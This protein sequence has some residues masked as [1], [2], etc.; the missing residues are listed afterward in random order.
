MSSSRF[1][2][3]SSLTFA[4]VFPRIV[5]RFLAGQR[6]PRST[7]VSQILDLALLAPAIVEDLLL[8]LPRGRMWPVTEEGLRGIARVVGLWNKQGELWSTRNDS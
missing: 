8:G 3:L 6:R 4:S 5:T 2:A 7:W 1:C